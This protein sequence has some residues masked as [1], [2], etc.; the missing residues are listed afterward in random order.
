MD[1]MRKEEIKIELELCIRSFIEAK[2]RSSQKSIDEL[3]E[4][5][6]LETS[7]NR[8]FIAVEHLSNAIMLLETG[9]FSKK[10]FG[11]INKLKDLKDKYKIDLGEIYQSTYSFR[12]Y[13]DYRKFPEVKDKFT[14]EELKR[15]ISDVE[16]EIKTCLNILKEHI[17]ISE[18]LSRLKTKKEA[19]DKNADKI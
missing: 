12:S 8:L 6:I 15:Q 17:E 16:K 3:D 2:E 18:L 10:H 11:D 5:R 4:L 1:I 7:F 13:A 14:R 9:N 19:I